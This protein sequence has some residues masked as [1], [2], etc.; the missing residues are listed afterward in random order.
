[1]ALHVLAYADGFTLWHYSSQVPLSAVAG[2]GFFNPA[3]RL[4]RPGDRL[5]VN[6]RRGGRFLG[7]CDFCV[8]STAHPDVVVRALSPEVAA[9]VDD[10]GRDAASRTARSPAY[11]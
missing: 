6:H 2:P 8:V 10:T 9:N 3:R 11:A 4:L 1:M 7:A 5:A